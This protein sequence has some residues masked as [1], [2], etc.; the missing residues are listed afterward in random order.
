MSEEVKSTEVNEAEEPRQ[1]SL[2]L[3][4][5]KAKKSDDSSE[6]LK[7]L[8]A[9]RDRMKAE[10]SKWEGM[11]NEQV[12]KLYDRM[13][14]DEYASMVANGEWEKVMQ[15]HTEALQNDYE[16]RLKAAEEREK[17][18]QNKT[19]EYQNRMR[20]SMIESTVQQHAAAL[21]LMDTAYSDA[22]MWAKQDLDIDEKGNPFVKDTD[23]GFRLSKDGKSK[24]GVREWL[25][26]RQEK[27]PHWFK[28]SAGAGSVGGSRSGSGQF[29]ITREEM[30]KDFSL[31]KKKSEE[32]RKAGKELQIIYN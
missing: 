18:L 24:M 32:A 2:P 23:G 1:A 31:Y 30:R 19:S 6:E 27:S 17:E 22:I 16:K 10:L 20:L 11:D 13:K 28:G 3:E 12:R 7:K 29:T 14:S 25:E 4:G 5:V 15:K 26:E 9:E 8:R 21:G